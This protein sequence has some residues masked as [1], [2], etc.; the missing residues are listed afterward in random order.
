MCASQIPVE[1]ELL[2]R[3]MPSETSAL[4][5]VLIRQKIKVLIKFR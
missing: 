1:V 4:V 2:D 3:E 5:P